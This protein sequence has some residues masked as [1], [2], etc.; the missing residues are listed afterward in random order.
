M[1]EVPQTHVIHNFLCVAGEGHPSFFRIYIQ[2]FGTGA[3]VL[4]EGSEHMRTNCPL[5]LCIFLIKKRMYNLDGLKSKFI[6][7]DDAF[8]RSS[9]QK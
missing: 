7:F 2:Q 8:L 3:E 1:F 5:I 9:S 6:G 4:N